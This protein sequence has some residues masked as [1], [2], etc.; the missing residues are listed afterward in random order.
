MTTWPERHHNILNMPTGRIIETWDGHHTISHDTRATSITTTE[1]FQ[2]LRLIVIQSG[3]SQE[4]DWD[5][6]KKYEEAPPQQRQQSHFMTVA[7]MAHHRASIRGWPRHQDIEVTA[8]SQPDPNDP[9]GSGIHL[10]RGSL[11]ESKVLWILLSIRLRG[12]T[13]KQSSGFKSR[14]TIWCAWRYFKPRTNW[15][16]CWGS[17][18]AT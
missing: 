2:N 1:H 16:N 5:I 12:H 17:A 18:T 9:A 14:C 15:Q 3:T 10:A 11:N 8:K 7:P 6:M 13:P 4:E